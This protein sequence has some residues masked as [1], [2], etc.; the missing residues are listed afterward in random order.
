MEAKDNNDPDN[1][2]D[3]L[4][5]EGIRTY[6]EYELNTIVEKDLEEPCLDI[7]GFCNG[8]ELT[9][10]VWSIFS[11]CYLFRNPFSSTTMG[12]E[13]P[14][15]TLGDYSKPSHEGYRNTIELPV[16]NNVNDPRDLA[17]SVKPITLPQDV[18]STSDHRLIELEI[19]DECLMESYLALIQPTQVNK[20]TTSCK[21]YSGPH[22]TQYCM[23]D[24]EQAFV[25]YA[26]SHT[27]EA[28][29]NSMAHKNI[30]AISH[31]EKEEL[32]N[33]G[34][35]SP[36]KLFSP[37]YLSPASIKELNKNPSAPKRVHFINSTVI[38]STDSDTK[39]EDTFFTNAHDHELDDMERIKDAIE[40]EQ[41]EFE[42]DEEVEEVFKEE[43]EDE[44][45]ES[46]N[47]FPTMKE[48]S[49]HKWK[50]QSDSHD[51]TKEN[52]EEE[53]GSLENHLDF[54][55]PPDP[56]ISFITKKVLKFNSLF[57]SLILVPLS[58]NAKHI[59]TKEEDGD[60]MFIKKILKDDNSHKEETEAGVQEVEY[61]DVFL[62]RSELAYHKYLRN[63]DDKRRGIDY[64][65][66]K[67]L[68][69]YKECLDLGPEYVTGM[70][71]EGEVT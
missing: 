7:D 19:Q 17:K 42:T 39:E 26:S 69:F 13:N 33:K 38:L 12:D 34:I 28:G 21:I 30:A 31:D 55:T 10:M 43:E 35:K 24:P 57:E 67:I 41:S 68:G 71:D 62:T 22:D 63:E 60:V 44:D 32:R 70:E 27:D 46:F 61:F 5:I 11:L 40:E 15:R 36:S 49:H 2:S 20:I 51:R 50:Q 18:P 37:K 65:M 3:I 8:G 4:K 23:E 53:R 16:G 14:I 29:G 56:S 1:I 48:L 47:S 9:G 59:C 58:P 64:V 25:E 6:E 66:S 52:E 45:D 54:P